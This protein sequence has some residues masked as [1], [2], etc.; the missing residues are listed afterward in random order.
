M[1]NMLSTLNNT[2]FSSCY[3]ASDSFCLQR[4][5][6]SSVSVPGHSVF[7]FLESE[8]DS[9]LFSDIDPVSYAT[10]CPCSYGLFFLVGG[11]EIEEDIFD[12]YDST[13]AHSGTCQ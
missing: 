10:S 4:Q 2:F 9:E 3:R 12:K 1:R 8:M 5:P 13:I 11:K 7:K 6:F